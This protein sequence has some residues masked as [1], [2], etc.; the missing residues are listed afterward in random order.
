MD[1]TDSMRTLFIETAKQ[2]RG[3]ARRVFMART[4]S[5]AFT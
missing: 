5:K 2:L 4:V 1:L 3:H